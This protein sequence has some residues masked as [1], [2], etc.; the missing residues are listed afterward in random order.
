MRLHNA[1]EMHMLPNSITSV[2]P[3]FDLA[4]FIV[5]ADTIYTICCVKNSYLD[6]IRISIINLLFLIELKHLDIKLNLLLT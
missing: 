1:M 4:K 5:S 2:D 3:I 6:T